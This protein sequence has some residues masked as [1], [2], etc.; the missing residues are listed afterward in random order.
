MIARQLAAWIS[1]VASRPQIVHVMGLRQTGKTTL[2]GEVRKQY[3]ASLHYPLYDLVTLRRYES[4]PERWVLEVEAALERREEKG[5]LPLYVFV[6]EIQKIPA[7]FQALQGLYDAHKG[8]IKLWIW[9]SSARPQKRLRAETLGGRVLIKTLWPLS[10]EELLRQASVVPLFLDAPRLARQATRPEPRGWRADVGR[11]LRQSLLPEPNLLSD[12]AAAEDLL[13]AYQ[14]TYLE[15]EIRRENLVNDM[16]IFE[17]FL[18]LAA[19]ED[20]AVANC[21][22]KAKPLGVSPN[23][24]KSYYAI[25]EDTF[26][27]R[28]LPAFSRSMRVQISKAPKIYFTDPGLARFVAGERG[29][30]A[31]GTTAFGHLLEGFAI[32]EI[33]KQVEYRTLPWKLSY[34]RAK[35]G[36]EVDCIIAEGKRLVAVE[37]KA[38]ERMTAS[39]IRP[40]KS[41]MSLVPEVSHGIVL[42]LDP[43][44]GKIDD[45]I[46]NVPIWCL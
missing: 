4:D 40:M 11:W 30:P 27:T 5:E 12:A 15:N 20:G 24:V 31:F 35:S 25:L 14:A 32:N 17:R 21:S 6:D 26:V 41:F 43:R 28:M 10:Q 36:L 16:G 19:S 7:L 29:L 2:F 34:L 9:G 23:T 22:A 42:S 45:R 39:D 44:A 37:V 8:R 33:W 13:Q 38:A 3:P 18:M 46:L 1:D